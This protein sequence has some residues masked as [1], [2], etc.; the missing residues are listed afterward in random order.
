[1]NLA[2]IIPAAGASQRYAASGGLRSKVDED[3]G[4]RPVLQRTVELFVNLDCV[5]SIIVAGPAEGYEEFLAFHGDKLGLIGVK[6]CRG[7]KTHRWE[8][9][10]AALELVPA[11]ATHVAVHD[12]ARP[13]TP[14]ELIERVLAAAE[15]HPAVIPAIDVPDTIKRASAPTESKEIDPFDAI[16]GVGAKASY[17]TVEGTVPREGLVLVQTPQVFEAGLLRRAY[18]QSDLSSTDDAGL[19]ER[20]GEPVVIVEGDPRNLKITRPIDL[21]T[22]RLLGG[23]KGPTERPTH[24][25]F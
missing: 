9:V 16:L 25:R 5:R 15:K 12:A 6:V 22:V 3:L 2:V 21:H 8:T 19:I 4:G 14:I 7:G 24:K 10:K 13:I 17:R 11:D 23:F 1:M 20:L 18:A